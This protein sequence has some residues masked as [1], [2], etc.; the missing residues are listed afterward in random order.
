MPIGFPRD[1]PRPWASRLGAPDSRKS[2]RPASGPAHRARFFFGASRHA[3]AALRSGAPVRPDET[4][5][6]PTHGASQPGRQYRAKTARCGGAADAPPQARL[7]VFSRLVVEL[8]SSMHL[9]TRSPATAPRVPQ[10]HASERTATVS[11]VQPGASQPWRAAPCPGYR[12]AGRYWFSRYCSLAAATRSGPAPAARA[13]A[14]IAAILPVRRP[15]PGH[16]P[17]CR[18]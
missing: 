14:P 4:F 10:A 12:P 18:L 5:T 15:S 9:L 6:K 7:R 17:I 8:S 13:S 1:R 11:R 16:R 2:I 3:K